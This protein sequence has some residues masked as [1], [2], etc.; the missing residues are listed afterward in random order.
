MKKVRRSLFNKNIS[1]NFLSVLIVFAIFA[2]V[3]G[4]W[5]SLTM[6]EPLTGR[7]TSGTGD[8]SVTPESVTSCTISD[9][10][11]A[12]GTLARGSS[13]D[14]LNASDWH[15]LE[16][17]GNVNITV[18]QEVNTAG[19]LWTDSQ[20]HASHEYWQ[21]NCNNSQDSEADCTTA[22]ANVSVDGSEVTLIT[23]LNP[24]DGDDE[25]Y[26]GVNITVPS[27]EPAGAHTGTILYTCS[28]T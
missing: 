23:N 22:F 15:V 10:A 6:I 17:D 7:A 13:N 21:S 14:S 4:T 27:D 8:V 19:E 26:F 3:L 1:N 5:A 24:D 9:S 12:F 28:A 20:Y 11:I 25:A 2:S 16:N 18:V